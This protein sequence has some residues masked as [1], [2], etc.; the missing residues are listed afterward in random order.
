M[1]GF[2]RGGGCG[3]PYQTRDRDCARKLAIIVHGEETEL[4]ERRKRSREIVCVCV[5]CSSCG[6]GLRNEDT[7]DYILCSDWELRE[8]K[9]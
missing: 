2:G 5:W 6:V 8:G 3:T 9:K 4:R 1:V 7:M